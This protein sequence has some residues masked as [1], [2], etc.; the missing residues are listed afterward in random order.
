MSS[1]VT[2]ESLRQEFLN[3]DGD[4]T[5]VYWF[6]HRGEECTESLVTERSPKQLQVAVG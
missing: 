2:A 6:H 1:S 3:Y 5:I 4:G